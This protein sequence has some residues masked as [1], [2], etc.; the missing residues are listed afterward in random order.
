MIRWPIA[1]TWYPQLH[2]SPCCDLNRG[3][4]P[5]TPFSRLCSYSQVSEA[6]LWSFRTA[7][8]LWDWYTPYWPCAD[9]ERIGRTGDGG[10]WVC[11]MRKLREIEPCIVYSYGINSDVSFETELLDRTKCMYRATRPWIRFYYEVMYFLNVGEIFGFDPTVK[12]LPKDA[13][14]YRKR[15]HFEKLGLSNA[16]FAQYETLATTMHRLGHK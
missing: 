3:F 10:K 13:Q 14:K 8:Y 6:P 11:G 9:R 4:Q 7:T 16:T 2:T 12:G 5:V 15:F 1:R